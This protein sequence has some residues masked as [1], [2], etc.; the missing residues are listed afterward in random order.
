[1]KIP[2]T[3]QFLL[4]VLMA[5][6]DVSDYLTA[7]KYQQIHMMLGGENPVFK[8]YRRD[9]NKRAFSQLVYYLKCKNYIKV[10]NLAGKKAVMLTKKG[11][12]KAFIAKWTFEEKRKRKDG[13][14]IM[15]IFDIPKRHSKARALLRSILKNLGYK[16]FQHSVWVTAYDV[17]NQTESLLQMHSLDG[18]VKIFLIEKL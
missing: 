12:S 15:I 1:M 3:D 14:W 6:G 7:N 11:L 2:I 8:K 16:L 9:M 10:E 5:V 17:S 18:Y 13:K 4:N